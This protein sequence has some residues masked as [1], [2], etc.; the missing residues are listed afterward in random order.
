MRRVRATAVDLL[1][2]LA[3]TGIT[4]FYP[5]L[6]LLRELPQLPPEYRVAE[7]VRS[8][9]L[10]G[11]IVLGKEAALLRRLCPANCALVIRLGASETGPITRHV[12]TPQDLAKPD[13]AIP[14]GESCAGSQVMV[15]DEQ[16]EPVVTG[17]KGQIVLRSRFLSLGYWHNPEQTATRYLPDPEGGDQRLFL[18]GDLGRMRPDG[19]LEFHGRL[20]SMLKIRGYRIEPEAI[21]RALLAHP[22]LRDCVVVPRPG[23]DGQPR[24][25]AYLAPHQKPGPTTSELRDL[26]AQSLPDYMIPARFVLLDSLPRNTNSKVDRQALPPPGRTRPTL[27]TPYVAPR[28]GH[29]ARHRRCLGRSP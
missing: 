19:C 28:T 12:V 27:D 22:A 8:V 14:V 15:V 25:V 24:L 17:E 6:H 23:S 29:E 3:M 13:E 4:I 9:F 26:L 20:D 2:W 11:Q 16:G 7:T 1:D 21:E 5:P 18:T 10:G